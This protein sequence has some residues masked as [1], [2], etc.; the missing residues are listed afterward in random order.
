MCIL[1]KAEQSCCVFFFCAVYEKQ[2][3][4]INKGEDIVT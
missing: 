4:V 1:I 3:S 2:V